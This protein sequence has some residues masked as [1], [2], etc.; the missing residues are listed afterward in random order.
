M[1]SK[2]ITSV[3]EGISRSGSPA[4]KD[5]VARSVARE[6][7]AK[8]VKDSG[9]EA[10]AYID[11]FDI[12]ELTVGPEAKRLLRALERDDYLGFDRIDDVFVQLFD[13]GGLEGFDPSPQLKSAFGR[14]LNEATGMTDS[15]ISYLD[16]PQP[17]PK[18]G[19]KAYHG[20]PYRFDEFDVERIGRGEGAQMYGYGLYFADEADTARGYRRNINADK[21]DAMNNRMSEIAKELPKYDIPGQYRQYNDPKGFELAAEYDRLME[22][23]SALREFN[24]TIGGRDINDF[25]S[26]LTGARATD[27]DYQKAEIIEQIMIDGDMLGVV[28]RQEEYDAY[29]EGVYKWFKE[30]IEPNFDAPGALYEVGIRADKSE[31]LDWNKPVSEQPPAIRDALLEKGIKETAD[32]R[33]VYYGLAA[34]AKGRD[35]QKKATEAAEKLGIKGIRYEDPQARAGSKNYVIFDP[36]TIDIATRYGI[37]L[38]MAGLMLANQEAEAAESMALTTEPR[39]PMRMPTF[40]NDDATG[41][42]LDARQG[43][44]LTPAQTTGQ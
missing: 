35:A 8:E 23:R 6:A 39:P 44:D 18:A 13:E 20:T 11:E 19:F 22:D 2:L 40:E 28:Q 30:T 24:I 4:Y 10:G 12:D 14:Y 9:L 42:V 41:K 5:E 38:P 33:T 7:F 31:L 32:G 34:D 15:G 17:K 36:R 27:L 37:A 1:V 25:Y 29:P 26:G 43:A 16:K 21:L 3:A